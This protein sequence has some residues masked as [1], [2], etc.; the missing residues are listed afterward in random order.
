MRADS[1]KR[2]TV[3]SEAEKRALYSLPDFDDFQ[4]TEYFAM[5]ETERALVDRR[6]G[7]TERLHCLLQIGYFKAKQGVVQRRVTR[8]ASLTPP[9]WMMAS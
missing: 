3:F 5:T 2:L 4:R 7:V 9:G 1:S 8:E 6:G